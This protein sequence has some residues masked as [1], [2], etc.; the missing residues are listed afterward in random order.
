MRKFLSFQITIILLLLCG[1]AEQI[2]TTDTRF[3]LDTVVKLTAECDSETLS[4]AF[5]LCEE[6]ENLLSATINTSEVS[7]LNSSDGFIKVSDDTLKI[8]ERSL[9][10]SELS[11]GK[12]DITIYP[13]SSLWDFKNQIIPSKDEILSALDN[14][15]YHSI[16][17]S[18]DTVNLNG[19]RID[20]GAVAK[21]YI[22]DRLLQYFKESGVKS[23]IIN[24][25]GNVLV[26]GKEYKVGIQTP[27]KQNEIKAILKL[28]DKSAVTSGVYQRYI[29]KDGVIYHHILDKTTGYGVQNELLSVTV[30]GESSFDCDALSTAC[31]LLGKEVGSALI[32]SIDGYEA[33]FIDN[34]G[35]L[36]VTSGLEIN[37]NLINFK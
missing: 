28:K 16:E 33:I 27:F 24:L 11:R 35:K 31:F 37:K 32:E 34:S 25:G 20:L 12:F 4:R 1:C 2:E 15:D 21:G 22:A 17:I 8:I 26:F 29:E 14:V 36:S 19:K 6:Y 30:T 7:L 3:M 10:Y 9:Y 23:G 18:G 5:N 13:L